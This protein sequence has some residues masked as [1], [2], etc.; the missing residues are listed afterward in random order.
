MLPD[1]AKARRRPP[2]RR[3]LC[4]HRPGNGPPG[5]AEGHRLRDTLGREVLLRGVN[6]GGQAKVPPFFAFGFGDDGLPEDAGTP[7]F[8]AAAARYADRLVAWGVNVARLPFTWE[9]V[10]PT[11]GAFD[12]VFLDRYAALAAALGDRGI[13][14]IV[15]FH[16]DVFARPYCGDGFP[17]WALPA[18]VP[19]IPAPADCH[20]WF[21]GY[22]QDGP[23]RDAF[24]RLWANED[25]LLDA[26]EA[27]W[28]HVAGRLAAVPGVVG[29]EILNEPG[30]GSADP[31]VWAP[32]V[33][34]PFYT[35]LAAAIRDVA[36]GVL[37]FFD[38]TGFD[39]VTA[40]TALARPEG[41]GLVFA[42]HWYVP[43]VILLGTWDG[44]DDMLEPV[45]RWRTQGD[46]WEV[47]VL[48]GEFGIRA[49]AA[50][51]PDY[52]RA[53]YAAFD[54]HLLH[55]TAWE[56]SWSARDWNEEGMSLVDGEGRESGNVDAVVRA[57][58][59]AV[60]GDLVS[61]A[62]DPASR[63]GTLVF[64]A[65]GP[66]IS[67]IAAPARSFPDGLSATVEGPAG[68]W[69]DDRSAGVLLVESTGVGRITVRFQPL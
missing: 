5:V 60:A 22:L 1:H 15:D 43:S 47:P 40:S 35:R 67:E 42:P 9:A 7:A 23:V 37:A 64:D 38:S 18:P 57:Y 33:L 27:M 34:T 31:A 30:W 55:A 52:L 3:R 36:P 14:V 44:A 51:G 49:D 45:G 6:A 63:A 17:L 48:I 50:D 54:A 66:G 4:R 62:F 65:A 21:Q 16:Q 12:A 56:Y 32:T 26:L 59:R 58:P 8:D 11:R 41:D 69:R 19:P 61:F 29:F 53:N 10:E 13:R 68:A 2:P 46:T 39:A 24:D 28:R 20:D 25:G